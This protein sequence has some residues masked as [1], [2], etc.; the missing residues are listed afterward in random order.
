MKGGLTLAVAAHYTSRCMPRM[1]GTRL[2]LRLT[3]A[4]AALAALA[5]HAA[6]ATVTPV[7][8]SP[9]DCA[10]PNAC[11]IV[12]IYAIVFWMAMFVLVVVGGLIIFASIRFRRRDDTEP[13]QIHGNPRLEF[14]WT[15]VPFVML[16]FIF[17]LTFQ[18]M[19]F[20]RNGPK[21]DM[22]IRVTGQQFAWQFQYPNGKQRGDLIIP[23]GKVVRL[24]VMSKDVLHSFWV[25]RL[26]GQVYALPGRLNHGWIEASQA[27]VYLG[28][29]NELCGIGHAMMQIQ[30]TAM[31]PS[32]YDT[33]YTSFSNQ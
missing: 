29:C 27:G 32:S 19:D 25:P 4:A 6:S 23:T 22:T 11:R 18:S 28:Q 21:E 1:R 12:D 15:L 24:E 14:A 13:A 10:G 7:S 31:T 2:L 8:V 17:G 16:L 5:P 3:G 33:W 26:G 20:V 30:V 9:L